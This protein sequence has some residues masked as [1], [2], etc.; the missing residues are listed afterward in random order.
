MYKNSVPFNHPWQEA[1]IGNVGA[2]IVGGTPRTSVDKYWNGTVPWMV[3]GDVNLKKISDVPGR[4]TEQGLRYSNATLVAPPTVAIGLAGQGKTRGTVALILCKLCTNQSIALIQGDARVLENT[5][6]LYNLEFRYNELRSR[7]A[8]DG[9]AG[10]SKH[11]IEQIPV[12]LPTK[13]EQTKIAEVLSTVDRA[14]EQTEALIAKQ[15]RIKTGLMQD[16]LT[17]GIDEHGNLR[18]ERTHQ[19]KDSPLGRIPVGWEVM[20]LGTALQK[21]KGFLQTGPFGSQLHAHEYVHDGIPV[22]MPQDIL[23]GIVSIDIINRVP[24]CRASDLRKHRVQVN[25]VI[26]SRRGDLSKAAAIGES[27]IGW[28][29]GT[30]CF[31]LRVPSDAMDSRWLVNVY[32]HHCVQRQNEANAVGSTMPSLNN[33]VMEQ[34]VIAFPTI[35]EQRAITRRH[36]ALDLTIQML[37]NHNLK[38]RSLKTAL[39]QDLLA[40]KVRVTPLLNNTETGV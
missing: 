2:V 30:G 21:A 19:F 40:G 33:T 32:R 1:L 9:R 14:I 16:L 28:L 38:L 24:E 13:P 22:I 6:L 12:P 35:D 34:L 5:Y 36:N 23:N 39:M 37:N 29:C 17:R 10:L 20:K 4:I 27:E 8:G 15:Q 26:F 11:L 3:S 31:L 7:S 25:D 18:S